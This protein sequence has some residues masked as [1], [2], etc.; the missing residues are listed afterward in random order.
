[1]K[2]FLTNYKYSLNIENTEIIK[3]TNNVY[4][5]NNINDSHIDDIPMICERMDDVQKRSGPYSFM[6]FN[7]NIGKPEPLILLCR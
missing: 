1:M 7:I 6:V 2:Q 5:L 4:Y 3:I